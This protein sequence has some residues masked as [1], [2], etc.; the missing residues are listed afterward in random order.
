MGIW[1]KM[2]FTWQ[3]KRLQYFGPQNSCWSQ[4]K[5]KPTQ[6][7]TYSWANAKRINTGFCAWQEWIYNPCHTQL[8]LPLSFRV[9]RVNPFILLQPQK[10]LPTWFLSW[11]SNNILRLFTFELLSNRST[12]LSR[13]SW[14]FKGIE[15]CKTKSREKKSLEKKGK[16]KSTSTIGV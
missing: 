9:L 5:K 16:K 7:N 14:F 15:S 8:M 12:A 11:D 13:S 1:Y 4:G 10:L 2:A 3:L 6:K